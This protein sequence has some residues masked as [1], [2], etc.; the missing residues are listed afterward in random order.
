MLALS[1]T[2]RTARAI[3]GAHAICFTAYTLRP[4]RIL[5]ALED[6]QRA[7]ARVTV[8]IEGRPFERGTQLREQNAAAVKALRALGADAKL[9]DTSDKSGPPLHMKAAVCDGV[10]YLD[11][12][13]W[14]DDGKDTVI[15]DDFSGDVAAVRAAALHRDAPPTRWFWTDKARALRS[16]ARLLYGAGTG[17]AVVVETESFGVSGTVYAALKTLA[18]K[19]VHCRLLVARADVTPR[20][21][22]ALQLM[23]AAGVD[24]RIGS[25]GEKMALVDGR[26]W[27]GSANATSTYGDADRI[28]WGVRTDAPRIVRHARKRFDANWAAAV[29]FNAP[30]IS[31]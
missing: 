4:G 27:L 29:P 2:A 11:D 15:R 17:S 7:G 19:G 5:R 21:A 12:R 30:T 23:Q 3:R 6:A 16:E 13:N 20:T 28:D 22:H 24:V 10:A 9:T 1:S 25:C 31:C 18:R 14:P 8:R 26:A